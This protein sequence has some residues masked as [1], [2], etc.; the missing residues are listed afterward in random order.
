MNINIVYDINLWIFRRDDITK[1]TEKEK[2]QYSEYGIVFN[3]HGMFS[4]SSSCGFGKGVIVFGANMSSSAHVNNKKKDIL[5]L[6]KGPVD[7]LDGARLTANKEHSINFKER[8]K[9]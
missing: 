3:N 8:D 6:E 2:Y 5:I 9:K 4:L 1:N 7:G